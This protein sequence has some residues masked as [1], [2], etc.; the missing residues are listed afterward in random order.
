MD[1]VEH[2]DAAFCIPEQTFSELRWVA[3]L[4]V[5]FFTAEAL[6]DMLNFFIDEFKNNKEELSLKWEKHKRENLPGGICEMSLAYLW[7]YKT[8]YR[9]E[10]IAKLQGNE[11]KWCINNSLMRTQGYYKDEYSMDKSTGILKLRYV[12]KNG[13]KLPELFNKREHMWVSAKA[14]HFHGNSK[15]LMCYVQKHHKKSIIDVIR[16]YYIPMLGRLCPRSIKTLLKKKLV[17]SL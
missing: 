5:S 17:R 15:K 7:A 8:K 2:C 11:E 3:N 6:T 10:N 4:G 16:F 9:V 1:F 13:M 14:L 12:N